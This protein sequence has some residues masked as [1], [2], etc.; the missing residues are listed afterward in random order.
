MGN[1]STLF[2]F[3]LIFACI[4]AF[5]W[6][7]LGNEKQDT[8]NVGVLLRA[9]L[10]FFCCDFFI[11]SVIKWYLGNGEDTLFESFWDIE[12]RTYLHY[13]I[14]LAVVS[15]I[16]PFVLK[17]VGTTIA[18]HLIEVFSVL[19]FG[20][21]F[22]GFWIMGGISNIV[23]CILYVACIV[24]SFATA[25]LY[26]QAFSYYSLRESRIVLKMALPAVGAW[27][28]MHG[29]YLP[30]ELYL[31]NMGDFAGGFGG[32][33][34]ILIVCTLALVVLF[35]AAQI[36]LLPKW[37][38]KG[39][40]LLIA[41]MTIMAYVQNLFLNGK[42]A[43][44][45]GSEQTWPFAVKA[46]NAAAWILAAI[47]LLALGYHKKSTIKLWMGICIYI[48]LIQ[49]ATLGYLV[50]TA[51]FS[52][53]SQSAA[54]TTQHSLELSEGNNVLVFVLDRLESKW[55]Q[56]LMDMEQDFFEPLSDFTF[57]RNAT[58]QFA[59]T[60]TSIPYML[61][62][63]EWQ[64]GMGNEYGRYAYENSTFLQDVKKKD[65]DIGIYTDIGNT[66]EQIYDLTANY[67]TGVRRSY[68]FWDTFATMWN[69]AMYQTAPFLAKSS[70][71][72]Y[73][74]DI[75]EMVDEPEV[76]STENDIPFYERLNKDGLSV[77][78]DYPN[79]FRFYHMRGAHEPYYLS[80]DLKYNKTGRDTNVYSQMKGSLRIVYAYLE[81][82]KALGLYED[83]T[84]IITADHGQQT[85]FVEEAAKPDKTL[86]PT[87]MVKKAGEHHDALVLN[88]AP[89]SH[90][91]YL[92]TLA[93]TMGVE[94]QNYGNTL[95][96]AP[97]INDEERV[98]VSLWY[99]HIIK[100]TIRGDA[101][102]LENW[103]AVEI[104]PREASD[105]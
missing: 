96:E 82:L 41:A 74:S 17:L 23:Y 38:V 97:L 15:V 64:E 40:N 18:K 62:G 103:S 68:K 2:P 46:G 73:T 4:S 87:L 16:E 25:I 14:P 71:A 94:V 101:R 39:S 9:V 6:T 51:D 105:S 27:F 76:W 33:F 3:I 99:G 7:K 34:L 5:L 104:Q 50:V 45:N 57:Y 79:A 86:M 85:Q 72:Y 66:S 12:P 24:L 56:E 29:V 88:E 35:A 8:R 13:G 98:C 60:R 54:L 37:A 83:A 67:K 48:V 1:N 65:F 92:A 49:A 43:V 26:R 44:L 100:F 75:A 81:Q 32:F 61:T 30:N 19:I 77:T 102:D 21:A 10:F 91:E 69:C 47:V 93:Q 28:F 90:R 58:S 95:E 80:E 22:I 20:G 53:K 52:E 84:I 36:F 55:T 11:L 63:T 78:D 42:L 89:V 59:D 31:H 70:Y